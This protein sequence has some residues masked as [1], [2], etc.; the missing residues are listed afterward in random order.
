MNG[1]VLALFVA[2]V[3]V[4][5]II[6]IVVVS[7]VPV[8]DSAAALAGSVVIVVA[9]VAERHT[10]CACIVVRPDSVAAVLTNN[11][12]AMVAVVA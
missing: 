10:V 7:V 2:P 1:A 3:A 8:N 5:V 11:S 12:F 9:G 6:V 4:G